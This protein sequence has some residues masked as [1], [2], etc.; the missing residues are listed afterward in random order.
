MAAKDECSHS[1]GIITAGIYRT[2]RLSSASAAAEPGPRHRVSF[3]I[4]LDGGLTITPVKEA[5]SDDS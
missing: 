5:Q 1:P 2:Y 4:G 3:L